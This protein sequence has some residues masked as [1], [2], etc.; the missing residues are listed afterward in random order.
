MLLMTITFFPFSS[1]CEKIRFPKIRYIGLMLVTNSSFL[2]LLQLLHLHYIYITYYI[3]AF[4]S[5][6]MPS[7]ERAIKSSRNLIRHCRMVYRKTATL[8]DATVEELQNL[9][10][11]SQKWCKNQI[12]FVDE[13]WKL[14]SPWTSLLEPIFALKQFHSAPSYMQNT[15]SNEWVRLINILS[16]ISYVMHDL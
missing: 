2:H 14:M 3:I 6:T 1:S 5:F 12:I 10:E 13:T 7:M 16:L 9:K 11:L 8:S 4:F 15:L